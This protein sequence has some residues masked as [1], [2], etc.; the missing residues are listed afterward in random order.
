MLR[1]KQ[2]NTI[3]CNVNEPSKFIGSSMLGFYE[4]T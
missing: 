4:I 3:E 1:A 2:P